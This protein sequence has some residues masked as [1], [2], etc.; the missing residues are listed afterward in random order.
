MENVGVVRLS[1]LQ[2]NNFEKCKHSESLMYSV[3]RR[4]SLRQH[5]QG[6]T[7][8]TP[9]ERPARKTVGHTYGVVT[10]MTV[11]FGFQSLALNKLKQMSPLV[12]M[13]CEIRHEG[14]EG[15]DQDEKTRAIAA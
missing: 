12:Y 6:L 2:V 4:S 8:G 1:Q 5:L 7:I 11:R 3:H 9:S 14:R 13:C 10:H 15:R